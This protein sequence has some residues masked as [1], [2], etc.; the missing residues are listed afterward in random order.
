MMKKP[1]PKMMAGSAKKPMPFAAKAK[2]S[3]TPVG[4]DP[5]A[6]KPKPFKKGGKV[7]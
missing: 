6:M 1:M 3:M 5:K 2:K 4:V 7:C